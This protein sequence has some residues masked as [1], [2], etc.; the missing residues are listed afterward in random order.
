MSI[1]FH[2]NLAVA[3]DGAGFIASWESI[4]ENVDTEDL[5]D[6]NN[7]QGYVL[8]FPQAFTINAETKQDQLC[9]QML[10]LENDGKIKLS[11]YAAKNFISGER[12][13]NFYFFCLACSS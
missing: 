13:Q 2:T 10:N 9:L 1:E 6:Q 12:F 3:L 7:K 5:F 8:S 11:I 4:D